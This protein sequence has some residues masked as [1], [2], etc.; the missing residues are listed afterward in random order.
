VHRSAV[1]EHER[2]RR[3]VASLARQR[4]ERGRRRHVQ[5]RA[6]PALDHPGQEGAAQVGDGLD[7]GADHG[8]LARRVAA[9]DRSRRAEPGVVHE[10][11]DGEATLGD[12]GDEGIP[13]GRLR[14]VGG[15]DLGPHAGRRQLGR[16]RPQTLL[17][18]SHQGDAEAPGRQEPGDLLADA[19]GRS[20]HD[21]CSVSTTGGESHAA[22]T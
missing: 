16:Q 6:R 22:A 5:D 4:L 15:H 2:L 20:R 21:A 17:A 12:G 19:R 7:V 11:V 18:S 3:A 9:V 1:G 10:H 8:D 13:A 14:Q